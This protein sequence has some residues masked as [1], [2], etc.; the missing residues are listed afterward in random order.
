MC[1]CQGGA[2]D[3]ASG[4]EASVV[5]PASAPRATLADA[6]R[7]KLDF[8][9]KKKMAEIDPRYPRRRLLEGGEERPS[10]IFLANSERCAA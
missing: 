7:R 8:L 10:P 4:M 6:A 3:S 9:I 5:G 2:I 1:F